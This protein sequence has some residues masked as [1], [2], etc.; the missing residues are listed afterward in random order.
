MAEHRS[1][2]HFSPRTNRAHE[3]HWHEWDDDTFLLAQ[4]EDKP[5]FLD[6]TAVWCHWCHV[7]DETTLS[8]PEVIRALN[9]RYIPVRV[10]NDR[11]PDINERYNQGGW[12]TIAFLTATGELLGGAT[13]LTPEQ[14]RPLLTRIADYY[15]ENR[16][17]IAAE[18]ARLRSSA[19]SEAVRGQLS[20]AMV[21][22]VA[23]AVSK[24]FEP[25]FGGFGQQMKFPNPEA[26]AFALRR[27]HL[28]G[29]QRMLEIA[30]L[31]LD[32]MAAG[33]IYDQVEGGFF[34]YSTTPDWS[35]PHFEKMLEVNAG[36]LANYAEAY[37]L[38]RTEYYRQITQG[39]MQFLEQVLLDNDRGVF[40]GSQDAD[41]EYFRLPAEQRAQ[42]GIPH[43]DRTVYVSWNAMAASAYLAAY[44]ATGEERLLELAQRVTEFLLGHCHRPQAGMCRYHDGQ[45]QLFGLL[46]DQAYMIRALLDLHEASGEAYY[47]NAA[48]EIATFV[49]ERLSSERGGF[50][51]RPAD[52][53]ALGALRVET[54]PFIENSVMS[55]NLARMA[56]LTGNQDYLELARSTLEAFAPHYADY[57]YFAASYAL[58]VERV[59]QDPVEMVIVGPPT[60]ARSRELRVGC[61]RI[62]EPRRELIQLDPAADAERISERGFPTADRPTLYVCIGRRCSAPITD[63]AQIPKALAAAPI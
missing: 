51:D 9:E 15:R 8:D 19:A 11:R 33:G 24:A 7:L 4:A 49:H 56:R 10:D 23:E 59:L 5:I 63:P 62:Y 42:R 3:I 37:H 58:A 26:M 31:T 30:A 50:R 36:L 44:R 54:R 22:V 47:L 32:A 18:V 21:D 16:E 12:P 35:I 46:A 52:T 34:R 27:H 20:K 40:G 45:P 25:T 1:P 6:L 41:E 2:F 28:T 14:M 53:E 13:Y 29:D 55:D 48:E 39:I 43:V 60:D 17:Q 38:T 61:L 57:G